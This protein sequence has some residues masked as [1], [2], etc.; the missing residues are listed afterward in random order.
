MKKIFF[1]LYAAAVLPGCKKLLD[2]E[3]I[4]SLTSDKVFENANNM[5]LYANSFYVD[6]IPSAI[7]I[8]TGDNLSDYISGNNI[9]GLMSPST[10]PNNVSGLPSTSPNTVSAWSWSALRNINYFLDNYNNN[11]DIPEATRNSFAGIARYFRALFYFGMVK[12]Y[13]DVPWYS[14]ALGIGDSTLYKSTDPRAMV[15]DSILADLDFAIV[16]VPAD[17]DNSASTITKWVALAL[18]SKV[19]L[20]EGTFRK[21]HTELKLTASANEF[22]SKSMDASLEIINS[23]SYKLHSTGKPASDYRD[24]F[25]TEVPWSDEVILATAYSNSLKLWSQL[26]QY[27][28]SPTLGNRS[29]LNKQFVDTYLNG[30]GSR[31]TDQPS[32]DTISFVN[33]TANRDLRLQQS[34]RCNKYKRLDGSPAPPDYA[35]TF[36]GYQILKYTLD[37]KNL[38]FKSQNNNSIPIFRYAEILLN[39]AEAKAELGQLTVED[40]NNTIKLIRARAGIANTN[41]P[42]TADPYLIKIYFPNISDPALLEIRRERGVELLCEGLRFDDIRRWKAGYLMEMPYLGVYVPQMNT[43]YDMNGDGVKNVAFVTAA[44]PTPVTGVSYYLINNSFVS[45]TNGSYGNIHWLANYDE[46]RKWDDK[47]YYY[48]IPT[49]QLVLNPKLTQ[50]PGW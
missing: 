38:D 8:A 23:G 39:Y 9:P 27:F 36:T 34:I 37:D 19:C 26:N 40:W 31:F 14:H 15:M 12:Q 42:T 3:P 6:Q 30:D 45:L 35:Y 16:N 43:L 25:T 49:D 33:E 11:T 1:L 46:T 17:K 41:Y 29:G 32:F 47:F 18:K 22:L 4:A 50:S 44:P 28:T 13:G 7:T 20:F 2:K 48:P 24:L 21:Y 5:A 10:N